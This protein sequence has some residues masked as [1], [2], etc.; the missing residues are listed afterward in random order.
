MEVIT[1]IIAF[2]VAYFLAL[3]VGIV[4]ALTF[5]SQVY[6][7]VNQ[8]PQSAWV[9]VGIV[10]L[11]G[12]STLVGQSVVLFLNRVRRSRFIISLITNGVLFLISYI[13]WGAI[14]ALTGSVLFEE[15]P[16][17]WTVVRLVALS[18]APLVF[19]FLILIPWMGPFIGKVLNIWSFLILI[20][21]VQVEFH[22]GFWAAAICVGIGWL[23]TLALNNTI[24]KPVTAL[25]NRFFK[26][27]TGSSLDAT[28]SDI[29]LDFSLDDTST[30]I[31]DGGKQ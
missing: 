3:W 24:G 7:I 30:S 19:G 2:L 31:M 9:L 15:A 10:V 12:A 6:E 16:D 28:A 5:N 11:A 17:V 22:S 13:V 27:V 26:S 20:N 14:I 21:I 18:T 8:Y 29:L 23:I 4:G 1:E 25:R